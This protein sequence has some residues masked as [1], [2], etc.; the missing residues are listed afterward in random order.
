MSKEI[1][2]AAARLGLPGWSA[3]VPA[4]A[5][6]AVP[7]GATAPRRG[8]GELALVTRCSSDHLPFARVLAE[9]IE[10][11]HPEI[12]VFVVLIDPLPAGV[13]PRLGRARCVDVAA[14][15]IEN[16]GYR[17][18]QFSAGELCMAIKPAACRWVAEL[19]Y[20]AVL[21][22]DA[23]I[24]VVAPME[25]LL[26]ALARHRWVVTPHLQAPF[27]S[28]ERVWEHP[29]VF[30]INAA[31]CL[32]NGLFGFRVDASSRTFLDLWE[33]MVLAPG[34]FL[35]HQA[36]Q[37]AFNWLTSCD[38]DVYVLRDR[39][40]NVAYWNL[41]DRSL[42][43]RELD[44]GEAGA[45][46]VDGAPLVAFHFSGLSPE[47]P[48]R[49]SRHDYRYSIYL[50]P[51][52]ALLITAYLEKLKRHGLAEAREQ[53][54][55]FS[56]FASGIPID[57]RM[58]RA[59]QRGELHLAGELDPFCPAGERHFGRALLAPQP[60]TFL[61]PALLWEIY[62]ERPDVQLH[63]P[64]ARIAPRRLLEWFCTEGADELGYG[65][66]LDR[67]RPTLPRREALQH[68]AEVV[69]SNPSAFGDLEAPLGRDR[70]LFLRRLSLAGLD[71]EARGV[72]GLDAEIWEP[73]PLAVIRELVQSRPDLQ[74]AFPDYFG[75]HAE[76][77]ADWLDRD[78]VRDHLLP[79]GWGE[80]YRRKAGGR[81]LGRIYSFYRRQRWL[82]EAYPFAFVGEQ[83]EAFATAI[84]ERFP[85]DC[86]F[87]LD[88]VAMFRWLMAERPA[89]GLRAML[90]A[91]VHAGREPSPLLPEGRAALAAPFLERPFFRAELAEIERQAAATPEQRQALLARLRP[92]AVLAGIRHPAPFG[93][94]RRG[95]NCFGYFKSPIGLGNLSRGMVMALERAGFAVARQLQSTLEM[96]P[97]LRLDD[98]LGSFRHDFDCNL[99]VSYPHLHYRLL[100]SQPRACVA[101]RRNVV[102]LA[103]EQRDGHPFWREVF[104]DFDQLWALSTFAAAAIGRACGREVLAVPAAIDFAALPPAATPLEVG[105]EP[106]RCTFLYVFDANSSIERKNP[107]AA[108][109]AFSRAFS[110]GDPVE[111]LI[112]A[113]HGGRLEHRHELGR[114]E[115]QAARSGLRVRFET[116]H[117]ARRDLLRLISAASA[118]VSLHRA[119][120]FGYTLA[121]AMAYGVPVIATNYSGNL[122]FM[123]AHSAHL[124]RAREVEVAV[125][126]GPFQRGSVWAEPDVDHAA[127]LM[128]QV[129]ENRQA[130]REL[131]ARGAAFVR[132]KLAIDQI[133]AL[134]AK[135]LG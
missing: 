135:A 60:G 30:E 119:E 1:G 89:A 92:P 112:K 8:P 133:A 16:L 31:G 126:D 48:W 19:G 107:A 103:W 118:Y 45:F 71:S 27:P 2:L 132:E 113:S 28:P 59:F 94:P 24:D 114:L 68:L 120:G 62:Q 106:E 15:G 26:A 64:E 131:G 76:A 86:E 128:R 49:L 17:R 74:R 14:L 102:Y 35:H 20:A 111:L 5:P 100:E 13:E 47:E 84:L 72:R 18:L 93:A 39:V 57:P 75:D 43:C 37:N 34:A 70:P 80:L 90:E 69:E 54:Y 33:G 108:I 73:S 66:L 116:R 42:R 21:S 53:P 29:G 40:Y 87:D 125:P 67:C 4:A 65:P 83:S 97:D 129:Y 3:A 99:F 36:E 52:V 91:P 81:A 41:H 7:A 82:Q 22:F 134:V 104:G 10:R 105:L 85:A 110:P 101:G 127:A 32:N 98:F 63:F 55:R 122:D 51:S 58:R 88:D 61:M 38:D 77:L 12:D 23:D 123:D 11:H 79:E 46:T 95:V 115:A 124:V 130:A 44:G 121:E 25:S 96:S 56:R 6:A 109:A 9:S 50:L 117:L 78:G